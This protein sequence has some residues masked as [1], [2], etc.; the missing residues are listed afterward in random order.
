MAGAHEPSNPLE[1]LEESQ[2]MERT[3]K[4][5]MYKVILMNDDFTPMEFVVHVLKKYFHKSES[6]AGRLMLQV[7]NDGSSVV[8]IYTLEV[9][10]TK[11]Y[12]VNSYAKQYEFPLLCRFEKE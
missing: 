4:P 11:T 12:Q 5:S 7:H 2:T 9:A 3:Q 6:E 8:G 1:G 10:E